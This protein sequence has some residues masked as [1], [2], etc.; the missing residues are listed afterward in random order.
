[1]IACGARVTE[2]CRWHSTRRHTHYPPAPA[3]VAA[4]PADAPHPHARW[5]R[6][7]P[8]RIPLLPTLLPN[9]PPLMP[10]IYAPCSQLAPLLRPSFPAYCRQLPPIPQP[11]AFPAG[12][13]PLAWAQVPLQRSACWP[14]SPPPQLLLPAPPLHAPLS[15]TP[16]A[17]DRASA[18]LLFVVLLSTV[19]LASSFLVSI[20]QV[21]CVLHFLFLRLCFIACLPLSTASSLLLLMYP[22]VVVNPRS[23]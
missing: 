9:Y 23:M 21:F 8:V 1:M 5:S 14:R 18:C 17:S 16:W 20:P 4:P 11:L 2:Y 3:A 6:P 7:P 19:W 22:P 13:C 15:Y 10:P 12:C